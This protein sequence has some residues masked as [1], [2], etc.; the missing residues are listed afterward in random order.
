MKIG[1]DVRKLR[2]YGIG[3]HIKN[4]ILPAVSLDDENQYVLFCDPVDLRSEKSNAIW[5][6]EDSG[7][8]S[9]REHFNLGRKAAA[10]NIDLFHSPHY[11]LPLTFKKLSMVTIHD[12][13]QFKFPQFYPAWKVRAGTFLLKRVIQKAD[14]ILTVS[15]T[16]RN[17]IVQMFPAAESKI[18]VIYNRLDPEWSQQAPAL[19]LSALG[20]EKDF[21]LYVGNFKTHKGLETL[22]DAYS[23]LKNPPQLVLVGK[24][25]DTESTLLEKCFANS[26]IRILGFAEGR[27]LRRLYADALFFVFPSLYEGFGYPPL[28]AMSSGT[29]VL[30]SDTP[31]LCEIL[32]ESVEF[33]KTGSIESLAA[34]LEMM[35]QD[36]GKR[37]E[38]RTAGQRKA[39]EFMTN[40]SPQKLLA[41]YRR[42]AQ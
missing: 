34:K 27:M 20:I 32:A 33:F 39:S 14:L 12:L 19:D 16:S 1:I 35:I 3:T 25:R 30:S 18:E 10:H 28:E 9:V 4:V 8:Y 21:I 17:D 37:S 40:D 24:S 22:I 42:F 29:P 13:I 38:L 6:A 2:D 23:L 31:A 41:I 15:K 7:K 11:T 36:S 26:R 5:V